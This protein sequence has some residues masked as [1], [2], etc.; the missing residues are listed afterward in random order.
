[1]MTSKTFN[2][3][4]ASPF[5]K[6]EEIS[7]SFQ[8]GDCTD[9]Q[10]KIWN[11]K[12]TL[13]IELPRAMADLK[14]SIVR[15]AIPILKTPPPQNLEGPQMPQLPP[16][17]PETLFG[18]SETTDVK[19]KHQCT[20]CAKSFKTKYRLRRHLLTHTGMRPFTCELCSAAFRQKPHLKGHLKA[21]HF[22][23]MNQAMATSTSSD[24]RRKNRKM[25]NSDPE[26]ERWSWMKC[27]D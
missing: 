2:S 9:F 17:Q 14:L 12:N 7:V 3:R 22:S 25:E 6:I 19:R 10:Y 4:E 11:N 16:L 24:M 23:H 13:H 8:A 20:V 26:M 5:T 15:S 21:V 1:M 27:I 18:S